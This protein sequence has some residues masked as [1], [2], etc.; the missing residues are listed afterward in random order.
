MGSR[1]KIL[2]FCL[3]A[4]AFAGCDRVTKDL[5]KEHLQNKPAVSYL[6]NMI[7]LVYVENTGAAMSFADGLPKVASFWLLSMLPLVVML[8]LIGYVISNIKQMRPG[9]FISFA[10]IIAGGLGNIYDR[11]VYDRHVTDFIYIG[12][13]KLHTGVFN[14]ADVCVSAG[15]VGLLCFYKDSTKEQELGIGN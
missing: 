1:Y 2:L 8:V 10:L 4:I 9:K 11:I 7:R 6:D 13:G 15:V 14:I 5:A 3:C 12:V